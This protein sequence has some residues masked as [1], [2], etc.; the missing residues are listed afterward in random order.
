MS[1]PSTTAELAPGTVVAGL[2]IEPAGS[3]TWLWVTFFVFGNV[4]AMYWLTL[5]A[6]NAY[7]EV[8]YQLNK[9]LIK[10]GLMKPSKGK[11][12]RVKPTLT[13]EQQQ[14]QQQKQ[15]QQLSQQLSRAPA[16]PSVPVDNAP[17]GLTPT[18]SK[19][20]TLH[21][22]ASV[23]NRGSSGGGGGS[24]GAELSS[25]LRSHRSK[26]MPPPEICLEQTITPRAGLPLSPR[27]SA[28]TSSA[29]DGAHSTPKKSADGTSGVDSSSVGAGD[30][31]AADA[32]PGSEEEEE[33]S[34]FTET[35]DEPVVVRLEWRNLCYAVKSAT[36]L[37]LIVQ[38]RLGCE[39]VCGVYV[40]VCGHGSW[41]MA[42]VWGII[43]AST[44]V[45]A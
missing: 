4:F 8:A 37:R 20:V 44:M 11:H 19:P 1:S 33:S 21:H 14:K 29:G 3:V 16:S 31:D 41:H 10:M 38:V 45:I 6:L 9:L 42:W 2:V 23:A 32:V 27:L 24:G 13:E 25:P 18:A 7:P 35:E 30:A 17:A 34:M 22:L 36:G 15:I 26:P 5:A 39:D 40:C 43:E 12:S 28:R